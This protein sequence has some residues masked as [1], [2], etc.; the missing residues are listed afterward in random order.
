MELVPPYLIKIVIDDVIQARQSDLLTAGLG[1]LLLSYVL[2]N[3]ASFMRA[4]QQQAGATGRAF[5]CGCRCS[6]HCSGCR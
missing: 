3:V 4:L 1:A 5:R 2:R 6:L